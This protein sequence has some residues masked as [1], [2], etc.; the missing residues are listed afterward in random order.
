MSERFS[1]AELETVFK[2]V[3]DRKKPS[4]F[5]KC[6]ECGTEI[7]QVKKW[8]RFC[9][10]GCRSSWHANWKDREIAKLRAELEVQK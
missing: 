5:I 9:S 1:Q 2:G 4:V 8:Q 3:T 7:R 6:D 10:D